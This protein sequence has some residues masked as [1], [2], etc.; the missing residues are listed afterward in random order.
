VFSFSHCSPCPRPF[1]PDK[2]P[3]SRDWMIGGAVN[4]PWMESVP[5]VQLFK[6]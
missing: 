4:W 6:R 3:P 1:G 5:D 2:W